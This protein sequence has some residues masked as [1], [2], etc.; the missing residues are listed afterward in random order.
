[1]FGRDGRQDEYIFLQIV[2]D[3]ILCLPEVQKKRRYYYYTLLQHTEY[4]KYRVFSWLWWF[5]R[6]INK[7]G[8]SSSSDIPL[9]L[10]FF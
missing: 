4:P 3:V 10:F 7:C 5:P 9:P 6:N 1:M 2:S 8:D